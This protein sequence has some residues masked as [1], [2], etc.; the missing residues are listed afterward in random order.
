[1]NEAAA[2][3]REIAQSG[4]T[5]ADEYAQGVVEIV[6]ADLGALLTFYETL[7][8]VLE[9]RSGG[10]AVVNGFGV[11]LF[12]AECSEAVTGRR[13]ANIRIMTPDVDAVWAGV[14][15]L[16]L[17]TGSVVDDRSYGL[18]DFLVVDP[19]GFEVRFAQALRREG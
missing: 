16:G 1:M 4:A 13:W 18:R 6:G 14:T 3:L 10:F 2:R 5:G 9:R 11:R 12:L 15:A 7:G 17:P 8:F 19:A